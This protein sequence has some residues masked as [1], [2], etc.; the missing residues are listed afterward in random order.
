MEESKQSE[1]ISNSQQD[2]ILYN[3][4]FPCLLS[5]AR[6]C[7]TPTRSC[8]SR[9]PSHSSPLFR[10]YFSF[11]SSILSH[12]ISFHISLFFRFNSRANARVSMGKFLSRYRYSLPVVPSRNCVVSWRNEKWNLISFSLVSRL[13]VVYEKTIFIRNSLCFSSCQ[14]SDDEFIYIL[15][16]RKLWTEGELLPTK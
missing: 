1:K 10:L 15:W 4:H 3:K 2:V 7:L 12:R 5:P 9:L 14:L 13:L 16:E 11:L 8:S 6:C